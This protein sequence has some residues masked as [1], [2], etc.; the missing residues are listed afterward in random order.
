MPIPQPSLRPSGSASPGTTMGV[1]AGRTEH[2]D[3]DRRPAGPRFANGVQ[4]GGSR[5]LAVTS[6]GD[7]AL[8]MLRSTSGL[9]AEY[10]LRAVRTNE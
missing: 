3:L 10:E 8:Q 7:I 1:R 9:P 6:D 4:I 5:V 2:P